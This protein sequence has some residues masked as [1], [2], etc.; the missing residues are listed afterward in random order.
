MLIELYLLLDIPFKK[1]IAYYDDS[2]CTPDYPAILSKFCH[3]CMNFTA[4]LK[5]L[6][7]QNQFISLFLL[8]IKIKICTFNFCIFIIAITFLPTSEIYS[9]LY[10]FLDAWKSFGEG[11]LTSCLLFQAI[12]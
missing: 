8:N 5:I 10:H 12:S 4:L 3:I 11:T 1:T 9:S 6:M 2:F 7:T